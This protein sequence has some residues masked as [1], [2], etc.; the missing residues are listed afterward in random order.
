M[1]ELDM[2][3]ISKLENKVN[4]VTFMEEQYESSLLVGMERERVEALRITRETSPN[5]EAI[6]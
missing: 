2:A 4:K 5:T 6:G 3:E 1:I